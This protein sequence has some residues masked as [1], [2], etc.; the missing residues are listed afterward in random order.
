MVLVVTFGC[1][2]NAFESEAIQE[3]LRAYDH[4]II[5]NTCAVTSEAERQ[6]RQTIRKLKKEN[7]QSKI[8]V[9]G[10]SAQVHPDI[11]EQMDEVDLVLGNREKAEIEK[12]VSQISTL[13]K[14]VD[15]IMPVN[16]LDSYMITGFE[17]RQKAFVQ[18]QQGCNHRCTYCIVP[19][20]RGKNRSKP[21]KDVVAQI[22]LLVS[23][24]LKKICLTGVDLCSYEYGLS[25]VVKEIF[26]NVLDIEELSFGSLDPA[27]LREDF[28]DV[29]KKYPKILPYFHFSV[30]SGDNFVLKRMGR[31]HTRED[32]IELCRQIRKVRKDATFGAD[33][34]CGF[35]L[36]SEEAFGNTCRLVEEAGIDKLHVFPYSERE[37]TPA[38]KMEQ[39][40]MNVRRKRAKI[41]RA[42]RG[43]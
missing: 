35:P 3:K 13:K 11:F 31:R 27:A 36:E 20:A 15:D 12:Y 9:T 25:N 24:G 43:E 34:I 8:V 39:I 5:V 28:I 16:D 23:K 41:L 22:K 40:D 29:V 26:E 18:I 30:Q 6:C 32:V 1:R 17:G 19:Y 21:I 38:A 14:H 2:I 4:L 10:C 42:L 37:G 7:P 33:F